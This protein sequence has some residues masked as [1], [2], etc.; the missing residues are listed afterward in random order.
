MTGNIGPITWVKLKHM[1]RLTHFCKCMEMIRSCSV[2]AHSKTKTAICIQ[3]KVM[4]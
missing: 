1:K 3:F 2:L 4:K